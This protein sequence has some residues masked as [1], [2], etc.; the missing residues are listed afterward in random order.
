M[1]SGALVSPPNLYPPWFIQ[2]RMAFRVD[3]KSHSA[4]YEQLRYRT[5]ASRSQTLNIVPERLA[6]R[7][8]WAKFQSSLLNIN[9][10]L[11]GFQSSLLSF[12]SA[13]V[14]KLLTLHFR[15]RRGAGSLRYRTRAKNT[16][17]MCEQNP[18]IR[19]DYRAG[20][21]LDIRYSVSM[22]SI[23]LYW[24]ITDSTTWH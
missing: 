4:Y 1:K 19:Y 16:V 23:L 15:I 21:N 20:A 8:W 13:T 14:R 2:Y 18:C 5:E 3:T 9:F 11:S 17:L 12:T 22:V 10:R 7:I 6:E 24:V